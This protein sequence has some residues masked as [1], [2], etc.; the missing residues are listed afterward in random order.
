MPLVTLSY[1]HDYQKCLQALP[2]V[3]WE[4]EGSKI[5]P[6][7]NHS[8]RQRKE[9]VFRLRPGKVLNFRKKRKKSRKGGCEVRGGPEGIC[10]SLAV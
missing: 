6:T 1:S 4:E 10:A 3:S 8:C 7:E 5:A 2:N 9:K